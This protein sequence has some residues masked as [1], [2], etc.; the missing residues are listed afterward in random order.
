I[1]ITIAI[2]C[3]IKI[4]FDY[5]RENQFDFMLSL[6]AFTGFAVTAFVTNIALFHRKL[7][8]IYPDVIKYFIGKE[9]VK[10]I[11]KEQ[12]SR[13]VSSEHTY[14]STDAGIEYTNQ[15]YILTAILQDNT[16]ENLCI[17]DK[18]SKI[19]KL[20]HLMAIYDYHIE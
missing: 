16:S 9:Q 14:R 12:I 20:K 1:P 6:L 13:I 15:N 18:Q 19:E 4:F 8:L 10:T 11:T 2:G 7:L 17:C 3:V 5:S